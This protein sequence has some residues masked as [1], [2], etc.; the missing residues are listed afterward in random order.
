MYVELGYEI[1]QGMPVY[2]GLPEVT[3][4][5]RE[6]IS[7]GNGWNGS[8]LS[9]Y[10]HAGTHADAPWHYVDDA[11]GMDKIP[12]ESFIYEKPILISVPWQENY[13]VTIDDLK[14]AGDELYSADM[15]FFNT[16]YWKFSHTAFDKY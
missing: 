7:K 9:M 10:L 12:L 5:S 11:F 15:I 13:L 6:Q 1:Y 3:V 2:P 14:W 16:G 4:A 8:V